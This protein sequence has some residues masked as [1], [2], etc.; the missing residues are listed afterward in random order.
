MESLVINC[1]GRC[2]GTQ[3][4]LSELRQLGHCRIIQPSQKN[5][6]D[7]D[8]QRCH[9]LSPCYLIRDLG[10]S[11]ICHHI[12][13]LGH[14]HEWKILLIVLYNSQYCIEHLRRQLYTFKT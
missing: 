2:H 1:P 5:I 7:R 11:G 8:L 12:P 13:Y 10:K 9:L 4:D 3:H 14:S 6:G